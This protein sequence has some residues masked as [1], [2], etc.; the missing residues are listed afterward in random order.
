MVRLPFLILVFVVS[1]V[2]LPAQARPQQGTG[3]V[4]LEC[5]GG[6]VNQDG[7]R[8]LDGVTANGTV[9][10]AIK[11]G[12]G[13]TGTKWQ[14]VKLADGAYGL[15]CQGGGKGPRWLDGRTGNGTVGLAPETTPRFSGARWK[16]HDAGDG[17]VQLECLGAQEGPRW[18]DGIT[19]DG[20]VRLTKDNTLSGTYWK[21]K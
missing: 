18:L 12:G 6:N 16:M 5:Q 7:H 15:E 13:F 11:T 8:F 2:L 17:K 10:L 1:S 9:G 21:V 3:A 19:S 20:T 14:I 4:T